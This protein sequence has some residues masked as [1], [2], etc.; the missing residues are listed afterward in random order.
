M[1][2]TVSML[3]V[4]VSGTLDCSSSNIPYCR[5]SLPI[6]GGVFGIYDGT[7]GKHMSKDQKNLYFWNEDKVPNITF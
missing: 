7:I 2:I 5:Y 4:L 1:N 3:L 6:S